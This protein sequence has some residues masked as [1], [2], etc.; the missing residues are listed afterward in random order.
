MRR[1]RTLICAAGIQFAGLIVLG[2]AVSLHAQNHEL[3]SENFSLG[4]STLKIHSL[5][6]SAADSIVFVNVHEDES[7]CIEAALEFCTSNP[8]HFIRLEHHGTR[9]IAFSLAKKHYF[10]DP[11]RMFTEKGR[12]ATLDKWGQYTDTAAAEVAKL[13]TKLITMIPAGS[14]VV[15]LHNNTDVNYSIKSYQPGGDEAPNTKEVYV[16][17]AMDPD[18]FIYTT[19]PV[20]FDA[21]KQR[22]INVILQD[23][24]QCI[25][26]GSMSVYCGKQG[27]PYINIEAQ[28]GHFD[29]QLLLIQTTVE[30]IR[31]M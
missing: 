22:K 16:N 31:S 2:Q 9:N 17:P 24:A 26:D 21:F 23:D 20:Y 11:N 28:K 7:T 15:A 27:I 14:I 18:D 10:F 30:V 8:I 12:K 25:D 3:M 13:A 19:V 4:D 6:G 1:T 29:E 5:N